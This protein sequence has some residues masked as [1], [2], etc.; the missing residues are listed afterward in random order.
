MKRILTRWIVDLKLD[1]FMFDAP[2]AELGAGIDGVDHT[3][4]DPALI[5]E[6]MSDVIRNVSGGRAAAFAEIYSDPPLM[7]DFGMDGE[8]ADD[9]ICPQHSGKYCPPNVR[10]SAIGQ[11]ILTGNAS[12]IETAMVGPGSVDDVAS[13]V[14]RAP[15]IT[16]RTSYLKDLPVSV[17]WLPG[18]MATN[19]SGTFAEDLN[20]SLG[21]GASYGPPDLPAPVTLAECF[22]YCRV[23]PKCDA[24]RVNWFTIPNNWTEMKVGCG[25]R[26]GVDLAKCSIQAPVYTS[27]HTVQYSTFAL[28]ATNK[29]QLVIAVTALSGYLPVVRSSGND[30]TTSA[31]PYPGEGE[32][33]GDLLP[34][35]LVSMRGEPS[36]GLNSLRMRV[37]TAL[38][39]S[40][41]HYGLLRYDALGTGQATLIA[42]NL[43][44]ARDT[45]QLDLSGL[46]PQLLGQ[47]PRN[48][49]CTGGGCPQPPALANQ[50]SLVVSGYG[51]SAFTGLQ[52][53]RWQPEGYLYN[54]SATYVGPASTAP[55]PLVACLVACLRD[56]KCDAITVEWVQKHSWP[57]PASMA[58]Y[59]NVVQ[60]NLRGGVDLS[61]CVNDSVVLPSH[62][63]ITMAHGV[64]K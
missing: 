38:P 13:Q 41:A 33:G 60:C 36:L 20:C 8:F 7:N 46:P 55:I 4:Y 49:L 48:L 10:S 51:V 32:G 44:A 47:R 17:S 34:G 62:S 42:V 25:L 59:G 18:S 39:S 27:P 52:L 19:G 57:R 3:K 28:D 30:W 63:T 11:A 58:W 1:G 14:F 16:F 2:D 5:R 29:S 37:P 21:A 35:L 22:G 61:S 56:A 9:K 45:V 26:G 31:A 50:T 23:D 54:C 64:T 40:A 53:P 15:G 6:S 24:V 43:G 12:L